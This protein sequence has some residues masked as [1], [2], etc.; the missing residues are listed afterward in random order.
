MVSALALMKTLNLSAPSASETKDYHI[1]DN[2]SQLSA[3][4]AYFLNAGRAAERVMNS[5]SEFEQLVMASEHISDTQYLVGGNAALMAQNLAS[6]S[7]QFL[8]P[9]VK[10]ER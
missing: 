5:A 7:D 6:F 4:L 2:A 1:L 10:D 8:L 3:T 9:D